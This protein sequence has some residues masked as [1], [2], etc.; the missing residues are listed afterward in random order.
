[1][2]C[3]PTSSLCLPP[4]SE[5]IKLTALGRKDGRV[6]WEKVL[7]GAQESSKSKKKT[8]R[9][10]GNREKPLETWLSAAYVQLL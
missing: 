7:M 6:G 5:S 2:L 3:I 1:M 10:M 8:R 4:V 9:M